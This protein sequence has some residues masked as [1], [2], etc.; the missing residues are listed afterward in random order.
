[1]PQ[2]LHQTA[3]DEGSHYI[4]DQKGHS[5]A[6]SFSTKSDKRVPG[7]NSSE[8]PQHSQN[9]G[10]LHSTNQG[11]RLLPVSY[12]SVCSNTTDTEFCGGV[13]ERSLAQLLSFQTSV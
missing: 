6:N 7:S 13:R 12:Q 8:F 5:E 2:K 11:D 4:S 9:P 3:H 10:F 1:M